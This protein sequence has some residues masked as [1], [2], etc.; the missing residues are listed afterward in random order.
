MKKYPS[1]IRL[2]SDWVCVSPVGKK[3]SMY[4]ALSDQISN[5]YRIP[6][7]ELPSIDVYA[8]G[9]VLYLARRLNLIRL[10]YFS[11]Q[12]NIWSKTAGETIHLLL[13]YFLFSIGRDKSM[14]RWTNE[15]E[16]NVMYAA[17]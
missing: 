14:L 17:K 16:A 6:I 11:G 3:S 2:N 4:L 9:A 10:G 12:G 8:C 5:E 1:H 7:P 15:H 13:F